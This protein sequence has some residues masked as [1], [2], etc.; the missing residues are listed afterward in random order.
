MIAIWPLRSSPS[1]GFA[2]ALNS[3]VIFPWVLWKPSCCIHSGDFRWIVRRCRGPKH[4]SGKVRTQSSRNCQIKNRWWVQ[5]AWTNKF[6]SASGYLFPSKT[7]PVENSQASSGS[8]WLS[9]LHSDSTSAA[10]SRLWSFVGECLRTPGQRI[11]VK[12]VKTI[13]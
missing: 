8:S 13:P 4:P 10:K 1:V 7:V 3:S 11:M 2:T 9:R 12:T 6:E 5:P